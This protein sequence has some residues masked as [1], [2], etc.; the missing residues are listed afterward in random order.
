MLG[1]YS[2]TW[3][4]PLVAQSS[5]SSNGATQAAPLQP[6]PLHRDFAGCACG[7]GQFL[8]FGGFD[9]EKELSCMHVFD[10]HRLEDSSSRGEGGGGGGGGGGGAATAAVSTTAG[11]AEASTAAAGR[12]TTTFSLSWQLVQPRNQPPPPR[13]HH[14]ACYDPGSRAVLVF[15]GYS[16]A[17][18]GLVSELWAFSFDHMEWWQPETFGREMCG[19]RRSGGGGQPVDVWQ[20]GGEAAG[21]APSSAVTGTCNRVP[22]LETSHACF[23]AFPPLPCI[24]GPPHIQ[25]HLC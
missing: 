24:A 17:L 6:L 13:S 20:C 8:T 18:G 22:N 1:G 7:P 23:S 4:A 3:Q 2:L 12:N 19:G 15:G 5:S 16:S 21:E 10:M 14:T 9:G 25:T 11:W